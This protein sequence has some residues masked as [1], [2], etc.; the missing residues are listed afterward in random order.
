MDA[1]HQEWLSIFKEWQHSKLP[2]KDF[3]K[4][5][6]LRYTQFCTK[7]SEFLQQGIIQSCRP[8]DLQKRLATAFLP[9]GLASSVAAKTPSMIE[10]Q[11]PHGILL[12][13]P[14]DVTA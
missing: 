8:A 2:Q 12:R 14:V 6:G 5:Q 10:I 4:A 13:I 7:R 9:I 3:C 11:L 1:E